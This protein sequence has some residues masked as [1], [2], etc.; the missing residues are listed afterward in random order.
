MGTNDFYEEKPNI[1]GKQTRRFSG[2]DNEL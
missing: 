2:S 1:E